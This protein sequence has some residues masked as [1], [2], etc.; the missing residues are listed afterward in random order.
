MLRKINPLI[1]QSVLFLL[2]IFTTTLIGAEW[3]GIKLPGDSYWDTFSRGFE[4]SIPFLGILTVHELAHYFTAKY[5]KVDVTLPYYLP[6]YIPYLPVI[7]IGTLGAFI[8]MN[9]RSASKKEI[10][11]IGVAGPLA[12]FFAALLILFYGFTHLPEREHIF[13]VHS[14]YEEVENTTGKPYEQEV[15]SYEY[16]KKRHSYYHALRQIEDSIH[17][18]KDTTKSWIPFLQEKKSV[19]TAW[20][21]TA[22]KAEESYE[23]LSIGKNLI[24]LF[25]ENYVVQDKLLIPNKYELFHYPL[26]FA[27]YLALFFTALNLFPIGQLDGGHVIYGLFGLQK[28]KIIS[29]TIFTLYIFVAGL[30]I[31]KDNILNINFFSA[32]YSDML[33]FA[34]LYVYFLYF[35]LQKTF[36]DLKTT[37]MVSMIIFALQFLVEYSFPTFKGFNGWMVFGV[38]LGRVIGTVHPPAMIEEPLDTKRKIIGWFALVVFILCF[39]P[40]VFSLEVIK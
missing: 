29:S 14:E 15:Y 19:D 4:Y 34:A 9:S 32:D 30:G 17:F 35:V 23:E 21:R 22:F 3:V 24:F 25:F 28:H 20:K 6:I 33:Y 39:T 16:Q 12:G 10:F 7:Q 26:L 37:L 11:D 38:L 5:Y 13:K 40:Q 31:F 8:K 1:I 2:T 36:G 27:G 18:E